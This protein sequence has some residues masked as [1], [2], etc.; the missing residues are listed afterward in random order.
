MTQRV[1]IS[2]DTSDYN[3]GAIR[4][5]LLAAFTAEDLRRFCLEDT[6]L[7]A[8]P[9]EFDTEPVDAWA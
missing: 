5:L 4:E 8:I 2:H 1:P 6:R 9:T 7:P 3:L